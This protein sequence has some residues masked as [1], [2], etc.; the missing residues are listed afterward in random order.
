M[1]STSL[2]QDP[3]GASVLLQLCD[4]LTQVQG[5]SSSVCVVKRDLE[6]SSRRP[7]LK[8]SG[9]SSGLPQRNRLSNWHWWTCLMR[10]LSDHHHSV[11][12]CAISRLTVITSSP[13]RPHGEA[14]T[15]LRLRR[16]VLVYLISETR[17]GDMVSK[18]LFY[19][20]RRIKKKKNNRK[21][22]SLCTHT[23]CRERRHVF[24]TA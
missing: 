24:E 10:N 6:I 11:G 20:P 7:V 17:R 9:G 14:L 13:D 18:N 19:F 16:R 4:V 8:V 22:H 21:E 23:L 12:M 2:I 5:G 1:T 15:R 3:T